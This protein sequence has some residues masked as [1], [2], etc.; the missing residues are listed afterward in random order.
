MS[1]WLQNFQFALNGDFG[2]VPPRLLGKNALL[3]AVATRNVDDVYS[4]LCDEA[5]YVGV[6]RHR[7]Q[8]PF[9]CKFCFFHP[10]FTTSFGRRFVIEVDSRTAHGAPATSRRQN[11]YAARTR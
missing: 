2:L 9:K 11:S 4:G 1:T 8:A 10:N 3:I 5:C 6:V 7:L